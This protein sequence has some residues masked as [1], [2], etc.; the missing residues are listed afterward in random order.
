MKKVFLF[1]SV[2]AGLFCMGGNMEAQN[3]KGTILIAY[4]SWSGNAK[5]LAEQIARET[6][7]VLFEIKTKT[8]YPDTYN[9]CTVVAR[10]ELDSN[11]RPAL[12]ASVTDMA[13]YSTVF[14]C[15]PIW[16]GTMPMGVFTFLEASDFSGKTIYP[17]VTHGNSRFGRSL[18]DLKKTC[19]RAYIGEGL[20]VSAFDT[21]PKDATR[22][23]IP[24]RDVTSWLRKLGTVR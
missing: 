22:V 17:L 12:V 8:V 18:D 5:A 3:Q 11:A 19:P 7:G 2:L 9:E 1:V 6:D 10:R 21:N 20:E 4:F 23:T 13:Q 14:L 24:N 16:W 15:Y